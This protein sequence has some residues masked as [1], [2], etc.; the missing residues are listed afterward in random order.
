M[1]NTKSADFVSIIVS[2][3]IGIVVA[4]FVFCLA[5]LPIFFPVFA[6]ALAAFALLLLV[7]TA[8]SLLR[9][10]RR[11]NACICATGKKLLIPAILLLAAGALSLGICALELYW[12]ILFAVLAFVLAGLITYIFFSLCCF[13]TCLVEAGCHHCGCEE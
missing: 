3:I 4:G 2:I 5:Y 13:L 10:D 12:P 6:L 8:S 11:L 7:L 9:Q 1:C